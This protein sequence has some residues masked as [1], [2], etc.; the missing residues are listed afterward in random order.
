MNVIVPAEKGDQQRN[1]ASLRD[2]AREH[3]FFSRR[4]EAAVLRNIYSSIPRTQVRNPLQQ[5]KSILLLQ[6]LFNKSALLH[7]PALLCPVSPKTRSTFQMAN[8]IMTAGRESW[9]LSC[10]EAHQFFLFA[11]S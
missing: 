8:A 6:I 9:G 11:S 7:V 4:S 3:E 5:R 1:C 10:W 2:P